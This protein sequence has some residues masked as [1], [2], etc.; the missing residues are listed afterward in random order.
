MIAGYLGAVT[1]D[2]FCFWMG[3]RHGRYLLKRWTR[4]E[5]RM[6]FV[7]ALL[8][9]HRVLVIA[10]Y[11][12]IYGIR[13]VVPAALGMSGIATSF[14]ILLDFCAACVWAV[15][16][17]H[18]GRIFVTAVA[19]SL[20]LNRYR[21]VVLGIIFLGLFLWIAG[22]YAGKRMDAFIRRQEEA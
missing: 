22:R 17:T 12:F 10:G 5:S 4:L 6:L 9:K 14:F 1:G 18:L 13:S 8:H 3:R 21:L 11:R 19:P 15:G 20:L 2:L 16:I 7:A